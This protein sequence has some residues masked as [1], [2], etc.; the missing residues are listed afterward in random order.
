M[1]ANRLASVPGVSVAVVEAG[2]FYEISNGNA[3]QVP[4]Y[5][6]QY[7]DSP[8]AIQPLIDWGFTTEPQPVRNSSYYSECWRFF[9]VKLRLNARDSEADR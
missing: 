3:S 8:T 7:S 6:V 1:V 5:D 4:A 2:S 9:L